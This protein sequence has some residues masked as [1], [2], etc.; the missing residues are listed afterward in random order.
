MSYLPSAG[1]GYF[2]SRSPKPFKNAGRLS[3]VYGAAITNPATA[4][5]ITA[6]A[7]AVRQ[8]SAE[9]DGRA[10]SAARGIRIASAPLYF[11]A[12][13]SPAAMPAHRNQVHR[14]VSAAQS[15]SS[16]ASA[17]KNVMGESAST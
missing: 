4:P 3:T 16:I 15:D 9:S 13:A 10:T 1:G 12:V 7:A 6:S 5:A 8:R 2:D 14:P 17:T 11:V